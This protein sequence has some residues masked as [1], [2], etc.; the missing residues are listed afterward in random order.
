MKQIIEICI[1]CSHI[2]K[3]KVKVL[4]EY[5][6]IEARINNNVLIVLY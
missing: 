6:D 2:E 1:A 4:P 5:L 3:N